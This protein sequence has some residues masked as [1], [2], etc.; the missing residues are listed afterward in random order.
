[1]KWDGAAVGAASAAVENALA[2][3]LRQVLAPA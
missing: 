3:I 1:M 2:D